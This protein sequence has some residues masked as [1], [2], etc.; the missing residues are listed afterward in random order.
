MQVP[1]S[2]AGAVLTFKV[3]HESTGEMQEAHNGKPHAPSI[4][5]VSFAG[6][7]K[8]VTTERTLTFPM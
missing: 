4:V 7:R 2:G 1:A 8:T 6:T 3:W 5:W